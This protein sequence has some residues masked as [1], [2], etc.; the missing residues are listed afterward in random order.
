MRSTRLFRRLVVGVGA[1]AAVTMAS[2]SPA[3]AEPTITVTPDTDLVDF[4]TVTVSGSGFGADTTL[5][6]AL[7]TA[8]PVS[9]DNCDLDTVQFVDT[10]SAGG[11]T[12]DYTVERLIETPVSGEVDCATAPG[13]CIL[14]VATLDLSQVATAPLAFDPNVPPQPRLQIGL[15]IDPVGS[16][17]PKTGAATVSGTV[18]CSSPAQVFID[19]FASQRAG[20]VNVQGSFFTELACDGSATWT[21]DLVAFNGRFV[22]G[23]VNID[24]FAFGFDGQ[25]DDDAQA[26]AVIRL[27]GGG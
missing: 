21:A 23:K 14:G 11:F 5:G 17:T 25:Q 15:T 8:G 26:S 18:T 2:A 19:G 6:A 27:K 16:V 24:A 3:S 7:C 1:M 13:A 22:G 4:Q 9:L 12:A 20:R 10:D